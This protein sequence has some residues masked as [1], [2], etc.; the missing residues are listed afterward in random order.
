MLGLSGTV[1]VL[2]TTMGFVT[3]GWF[4]WAFLRGKLDDPEAQAVVLFDDR[5]LR[6]ARPWE[7]RVEQDERRRR[8]GALLPPCPADWGD[9]ARK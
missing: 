4:V 3:V 2:V 8:H 1:V 7:S 9:G 6:L 5:D